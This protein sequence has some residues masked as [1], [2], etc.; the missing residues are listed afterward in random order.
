M[1]YSLALTNKIP[2]S[3]TLTNQNEFALVT[4]WDL[5]GCKGQLAVIAL[6]GQQPLNTFWNYEWTDLYPGFQNYGLFTYMKLLGVLDLPGMQAPTAVTA[7]TDHVWEWFYDV[8]AQGV[9]QNVL[10]GNFPL[11][12]EAN[13]QTFID[14]FNTGKYP[15]SGYAVVVSKS[16]KSMTLIDLTP[17]FQNVTDKYFGTLSD[18]ESTRDIG[19]DPNQWPLTFLAN[20]AETPI[21]VGQYALSDHPVSIVA[22]TYYPT[23]P[24]FTIGMENGGL[25]FFNSI[26]LLTAATNSAIGTSAPLTAIPEFT[27]PLDANVTSISYLKGKSYNPYQFDENWMI[28]LSRST[29]SVYW[30]DISGTQPRVVHHLRDSRIVD[31]ISAEDN[32]TH[33][34]ESYVIDIS[35]YGGKQALAYRYGPVILHTNGGTSYGMGPDGT[36]EFEFGGAYAVKGKPFKISVANV[37]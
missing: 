27:M 18:F 33:G 20:P 34:T 23:Q 7:A 30:I 4:L 10:P 2:T 24:T 17:L 14:G 16:E 8:N 5:N 13:R 32:D 37:P 26:Q 21:I 12:N 15:K 11:T 22:N 29:G 1:F 25:Q 6:G 35:D 31:P 28:A 19:P 3:I 36:A 9:I